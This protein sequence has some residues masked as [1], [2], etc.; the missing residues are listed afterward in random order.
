[1][2]FD[3]FCLWK[4]LAIAL[5]SL[6]VLWQARQRVPRPV[7]LGLPPYPTARPYP[8][9][10]KDNLLLNFL[11]RMCLTDLSKSQTSK[12]WHDKRFLVRFVNE[13][14]APSANAPRNIFFSIRS[15]KIKDESLLP[16][17]PKEGSSLYLY[18]TEV[19]RGAFIFLN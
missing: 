16:T 7:H 14:S 11:L 15:K 12:I 9:K 2:I 18:R 19:S 17:C 8:L 4:F 13:K 10:V 3:H 5:L 6:L 1:M